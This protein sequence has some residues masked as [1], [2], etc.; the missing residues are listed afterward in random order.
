MSPTVN[1]DCT[2]KKVIEPIVKEAERVRNYTDEDRIGIILS[3]I[4]RLRLDNITRKCKRYRHKIDGDTLNYVVCVDC[5]ESYKKYIDHLE[6]T[7]KTPVNWELFGALIGVLDENDLLYDFINE[8]RGCL[9]C[10]KDDW[11]LNFKFIDPSQLL[12]SVGYFCDKRAAMVWEWM[13]GEMKKIDK[14]IFELLKAR[15]KYRPTGDKLV[16]KRRER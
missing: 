9:T 8:N 10:Y 3:F 14:E 16:L 15:G 12:Y 13:E 11:S 6:E 4:K 7:L 5:L 2:N 1:I